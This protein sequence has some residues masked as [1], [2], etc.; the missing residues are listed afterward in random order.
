MSQSRFVSSIDRTLGLVSILIMLVFPPVAVGGDY[1][2]NFQIHGFLTQTARYTS[3]NA[4]F[5]DSEDQVALGTTEMGLNGTVNA[6]P[7][8]RLAAQGLLRR[9]GDLED[10]DLDLDYAFADINLWSSGRSYA[11]MRGGR[12]KNPWGLYNETRDVAHTRPSILLPQSVY[13]ERSRDLFVSSDGV[14][15]YLQSYFDIG[16][17]TVETG[18]TNGRPG[19]QVVLASLGG[20]FPG[21]YKTEDPVWTTRILFENYS[22]LKLGFTSAYA[23]LDYQSTGRPED[24]PSGTFENELYIWS[25]Q[26]SRAKW[27][28]TSEYVLNPYDVRGFDFPRNKAVADGFYVQGI[29]RLTP[30]I[31]GLLRYDAFYVDRSDRQGKAFEKTTGIPAHDAFAKDFTVGLRWDVTD[32]LL[33]M[34]EY[35]NN[36]G[37]RLVPFSN[38]DRE[39]TDKRWDLYELLV[40]YTF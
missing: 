35:H 40:S 29:Y 39:T 15:F 27:S 11:G 17:L 7:R 36:T 12:I 22:G 28:L 32:S 19:E 26:Y 34:V 6:T 31:S 3:A 24:Q 5:S 38:N 18:L 2:R 21:E 20:D 4:Y 23:K 1:F 37:T 10:F 25:L 14:L 13:I 9:P 30:R 8:V 16:D 33:F